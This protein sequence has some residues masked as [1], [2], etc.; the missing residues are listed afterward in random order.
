VR[1]TGVGPSIWIQICFVGFV[2]TGFRDYLN[3]F[4][5]T[6]SIC[7]LVIAG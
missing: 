4:F 7:A 6:W 2:S 1:A 3:I 5:T